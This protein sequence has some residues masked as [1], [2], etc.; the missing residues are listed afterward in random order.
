MTYAIRAL[1]AGEIDAVAGAGSI[2]TI[3]VAQTNTGSS[4]ATATAGSAYAHNDQ[5]NS[6]IIL[7][8]SPVKVSVRVSSDH[9]H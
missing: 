4:I 5:S 9:K 3:T 7:N 2:N 1:T 8:Q 6:S